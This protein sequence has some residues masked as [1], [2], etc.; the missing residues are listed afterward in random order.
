[1]PED[2]GLVPSYRRFDLPAEGRRKV[3]SAEKENQ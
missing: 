3:D 1:M 2:G